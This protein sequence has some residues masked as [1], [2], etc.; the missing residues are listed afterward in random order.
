MP[1]YRGDLKMDYKHDT[2]SR[3]ISPNGVSFILLY[4]S[5]V[6]KV[7]TSFL[8]CHF[9]CASLNTKNVIAYLK[10]RRNLFRQH[11]LLLMRTYFLI[12]FFNLIL[13]NF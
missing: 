8:T 5:C 1:T 11:V 12:F 7:M 9:E 4:R 10:L 6:V 2:T 3:D 13:M